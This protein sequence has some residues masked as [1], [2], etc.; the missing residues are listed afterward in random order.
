MLGHTSKTIMTVTEDK[1]TENNAIYKSRVSL[2]SSTFVLWQKHAHTENVHCYDKTC[3][4]SRM[5]HQ[6]K[7]LALSVE[8]CLIFQVI[9]KQSVDHSHKTTCPLLF[10]AM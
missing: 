1:R 3:E 7:E 8:C 5:H 9:Y 6:V 10:S 2:S 4:Y